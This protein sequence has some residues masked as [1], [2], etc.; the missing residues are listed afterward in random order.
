MS[1][2]TD[3]GIVV[4]YHILQ[5]IDIGASL[6]NTI[7]FMPIVA[8]VLLVLESVDWFFPIVPVA[9]FIEKS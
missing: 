6:F 7:H 3:I 8:V 2:T 1:Y 5:V 9:S 4:S